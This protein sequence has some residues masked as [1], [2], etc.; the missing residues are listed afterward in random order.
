MHPQVLTQ[1]L[2]FEAFVQQALQK[3]IAEIC[4]TDHMPLSLSHATDRLPRGKVGEYCARV[5]ELAS[6]YEGQISI[7]CGIEIDYHPSVLGEIEDV[8]AQGDFDY[9]LGSSHLHVF[10][11]NYTEYSRNSFAHAALENSI[12]A[13]NS[14]LFHAISHP[15]MY[16]FVFQNPARF[17]LK[18]DGYRAELHRDLFEELFSAAAQKKVYLEINPHLAEHE[19]SLDFMYPEAQVA[20]WALQSGVRFSYGSDAHKPSSVG[21]YLDELEAH[22]VYGKALKEWES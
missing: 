2:Q 14:G 5:R 3:N 22:P 21:A 16:R 12:L 1:P 6:R 9:I 18:D 15:D 8:L 13:A 7:K 17:P 19:C 10:V 20:Q 11:K 4:V